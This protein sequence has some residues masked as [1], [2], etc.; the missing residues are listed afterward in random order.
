[1]KT[2]EIDLGNGSVVIAVECPSCGGTG[3]MTSVA[4]PQ[5]TPC[6]GPG[7]RQSGYILNDAGK[8]LSDFIKSNPRLF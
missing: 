2:R 7:C 5:G 4:N 3:A 1:M 8:I 6:R